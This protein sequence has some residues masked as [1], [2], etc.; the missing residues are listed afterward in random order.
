MSISAT[1]TIEL[2]ATVA[3]VNGGVVDGGPEW[4]E[5]TWTPGIV[6]PLIVTAIFYAG[7][8]WRMISQPRR[9]GLGIKQPLFFAI[10]WISLSL[11][12]LSPIHELGE[13]LF[14]VHMA[15]HEILILVCAP[16]LVLGQPLWISLWS[17]PFPA[18][19]S[20]AALVKGSVFAAVWAVISA[21]ACTWILHAAALWIWHIPISFDATLGSPAIHATQHISFLGTGLLF[22]WTVLQDHGGRIGYG[23][24]SLYVFTTAVHTSLLG[25][26]LTFSRHPWYEPYAESA[27]AWHLTGLED[28]QLGGLIMWVPGGTL[29]LAVTL[30]MMTKWLRESELRGELTS[31]AALLRNGA[32]AARES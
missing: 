28:Q 29:L 4:N 1:I 6:V 18:R 24:G 25:A 19:K 2:L 31:T 11:A 16:F 5:W 8:V 26:L 12:L 10:G 22:W 32:S 9:A 27:R 17:L 21:P 30:V 23:T 15:Q 3:K 14:W 7:G 20:V 13:Q